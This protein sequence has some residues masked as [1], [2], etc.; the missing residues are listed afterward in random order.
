MFLHNLSAYE[1]GHFFKSGKCRELYGEQTL[2]RPRTRGDA[3]AAITSSITDMGAPPDPGP[4][5]I[6]THPESLFRV[7]RCIWSTDKQARSLRVFIKE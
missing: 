4:G 2:T 7:R 5:A 1:Q 6:D 3:A